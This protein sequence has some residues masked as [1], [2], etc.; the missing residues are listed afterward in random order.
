VP[1][2]AQAGRPAAIRARAAAGATIAGRPQRIARAVC[3]P[4]GTTH[5]NPPS[6]KPMS[7]GQS[8]SETTAKRTPRRN[9]PTPCTCA[10]PGRHSKNQ[11]CAWTA[12]EARSSVARR[13]PRIR[14]LSGR[15]STASSPS[16]AGIS[17]A[18]SATRAAV[19]PNPKST[20]FVGADRRHLLFRS[21]GG[22]HTGGA[23]DD[24]SLA[25]A[26]RGVKRSSMW[27]IHAGRLAPY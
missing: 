17:G 11:R 2:G 16:L 12:G 26:S 6:P 5:A 23:D 18:L 25:A 9:R 3:R 24:G 1:L 20:R 19:P 22:V 27:L 13:P 7:H 10:R 14:W 4:L 8:S 15:C 21:P